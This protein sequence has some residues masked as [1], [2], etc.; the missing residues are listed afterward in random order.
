MNWFK[1][2][3][4][5]RRL[6][7]DLSDE[8]RDHLDEKI[9]ELVATGLPRKEAMAAAR[10]QFGNITLAEQDSRE[11]WQWTKIESLFADLRFAV[12][13]LRKTPAFTATAILTLALGIGANTAIFTLIDALMLRTLPVR[14]PGQ[15]VE[16]LHRFPGEPELSGFSQESYQLMRD[17]NH[18]F[19]GLIAST[20]ET[21]QLP[22]SGFESQAI[23]GGFV[24]GN[25]FEVLGLQPAFGR[26]IGPQD[27]QADNPEAVAVVS[28]SY[29]KN[30]FNLDSSIL[31][32]Q[33]N[34]ENV[35]VTVVG[36]APRGFA[37]LS[38]ES[39]QDIWLPLALARLHHPSGV[40]WGSL[41]LVGRLKPGIAFEQARA[42]MAVLFFSTMQAPN[43]NPFLR[44]MKFEMEPAG[45]GLTS[46]LRQQFTTPLLVL[47]AT[48]G[49]LL[50]I[51]CTNIASLL[52]ARG[53]AAQHEM[54]LRVALGAGRLRLVRLV[55]AEP[56]L[57]SAASSLLAI[58]LAYFGAGAL[59]RIILSGHDMRGMPSHFEI[60]VNPDLQVLLF[61]VTVALLTVVISGLSPALR[62]LSTLPASALRHVGGTG[63]SRLHR[64]FGKSLVVT[65]VA[66]SVV[67]FS[68][69]ALFISYLS[70]LEH[71]NLGF[72]RDHLLL[73]S[74]DSSKSGYQEDQ[75]SQIY[76][77]LL[78]RLEAI[79]G[80]RSATL[81]SMTPISGRARACYCV[82]VEGREEKPENHR[83]MVFINSVAPNYFETY[84]TP[85]LSGRG[86]TEQDQNGPRAS[87]INQ[88]MARYYFGG[89]SPIGKR[90]TFDL[91]DKP[92]EIVGVAGDAKY[93]DI[94]EAPPHTIYL[95]TFQES[96]ISS[97]FTIRTSLDPDAL[98]PEVRSAATSLLKSIPVA[99]I[100]TMDDQLDAS[101]VPERFIVT[102]SGWFGALGALLV[103]IGLYGLL[104][105]AVA[106]RI[107]E[108]GV[109][110]ALGA[111]RSDVSRMVLG[112]ALR[113]VS[114][115]LIIGA[116][117]AFWAKHFAAHF[118][119]DLPSKTAA[120]IVMGAA[121]MLA[122][123]LLAAYLPARRASRVDPM[124]ALR[125]E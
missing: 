18:V 28:W 113:L 114:A 33:I 75:L 84:G 15:L 87:I 22:H 52:L 81:S 122:I 4:S 78:G 59:V 68:A 119:Q 30:T 48:V 88:T 101:I 3:F 85:L 115:G 109:R 51:A 124:V 62:V 7:N 25:Y 111:T 76:K 89:R 96:R 50:L 34:L 32:K 116:P 37:G 43:P 20:H 65:Q 54:A 19:S 99:Q 24:D 12:R 79:P 36:V 117:I 8:I 66:L 86:F 17:H 63:E 40:G 60:Q 44:N 45:T 1:Q 26:L 2:L 53:A 49:L 61:T 100:T 42:D 70:N 91:D 46:P 121:A 41:A 29:W 31:G 102:L 97:Q 47:M 27:D 9:G 69:A 104:S 90:L 23:D 80:V 95:D 98:A 56:F 58:V 120:P 106:R 57:I 11:V 39:T 21:F 13:T 38:E 103:A 92:Y 71:L 55:L 64:L 14:D 123:A 16:L 93:N 112:E 118:I 108:I 67:L 105:Y 5:R 94:R 110:I 82:S 83:D 77:E 72:R 6:Y 10:R 74:L 35:P 73:V 107:N 125:Y